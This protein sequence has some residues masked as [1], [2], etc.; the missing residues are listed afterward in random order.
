MKRVVILGGGYAGVNAAK[1][2]EKKLYQ[3]EKIEII[4]INQKEDHIMRTSLHEVAGGRVSKEAVKL[5]LNDIFKSGKVRLVI[6][7]VKHISFQ[8]QTI[9]L[10]NQEKMKYDYLVIGTGS[11]PTFF[12]IEGA[13]ENSLPLWTLNDAVRIK[14]YISRSFMVASQ[15]KNADDRRKQLSFIIAG[16]GFTG[17]ELAGELGEWKNRLCSQ[18]NIDPKE[19]S[20]KIIEALP[21]ILNNLNDRLIIKAV[22]RLGNLG[23]EVLTNSKISKVD[24][25]NVYIQNDLKIPGKL[26]WAAGVQGNALNEDLKLSFDRKARIN[27]DDY[28]RTIDY[29]N[30]YCVGDMVHFKEKGRVIPQIVETALQ[31]STVAANNI[32]ADITGSE[33]KKFQSN[34][35]GSMVSIGSK[36]GVAQVSGISISGKVAILLKHLVNLHYYHGLEI[37]GSIRN[38]LKNEFLSEKY[39][40]HLTINHT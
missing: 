28:M 21:K 16:G 38:Y 5:T 18:Y 24:E 23:V 13:K 25:R 11:K 6:D 31:T 1:Q 8:D 12:N 26:I 10:R 17:V 30:V 7:R 40:F 37:M 33:K 22:R 9:D 35:H 29:K 20:I 2:L 4:L 3:K 36:Y 19:V 32:I 14:R 15:M 27:V 34:Y 39:N